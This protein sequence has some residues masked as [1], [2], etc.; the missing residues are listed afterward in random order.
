MLSSKAKYALRAMLV[1]AEAPR[2]E[3]VT[4]SAIAEAA[5]IPKK[6]LELILLDLKRHNLIHSQ[7]GRQGGY[8]LSRAPKAISFGEIVRDIDGPLA[9]VPC[10]SKSFYR[11]CEDCVDEKTCE[12]RQV[13]ARVREATAAILDRTMLSDA[14]HHGR[15][16]RARRLRASL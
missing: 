16:A 7:R 6:F 15:R 8:S 13:M 12:I 1:L 3:P 5:A 2:G 11:R 10:V 14:L 9:A 4:I